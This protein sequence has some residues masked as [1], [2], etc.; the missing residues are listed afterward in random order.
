MIRVR[1]N[2]KHRK[3]ILLSIVSIIIVSFIVA[4]FIGKSQ[5]EQFKKEVDLYAAA[6]SLVSERKYTEATPIIGEL[7]KLKPDSE[8]TSYLGSIVYANN[9]DFQQAA[10]LMQKALDINPYKVE[11]P[12]FMLQFGEILF[13]TERYEDAKI[14]LERC[15]ESG[16]VTEEYPAYQERVQEL[17]TYIETI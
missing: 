14:V 1:L 6:S 11:D 2:E 12:M 3:Y 7:L 17:L 10:I 5:D 16:W 9:G 4:K 8:A 13:F 15:Q